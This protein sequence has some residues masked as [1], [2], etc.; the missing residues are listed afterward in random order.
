ML[1]LLMSSRRYRDLSK[2]SYQACADSDQ[3]DNIKR[4]K[5]NTVFIA[6]FI[7]C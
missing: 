4:K 6:K 3:I 5:R 2:D 1:K 7:M